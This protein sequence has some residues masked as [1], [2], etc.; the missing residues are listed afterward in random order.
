MKTKKIVR[1]LSALLAAVILCTAFALSASAFSVSEEGNQLYDVTAAD[2]VEYMGGT[3]VLEGENTVKFIE[4]TVIDYDI[5]VADGENIVFDLNGQ[6]VKFSNHYGPAYEGEWLGSICGNGTLTIKDS[7]GTGRF[8]AV[9]FDFPTVIIEGGNF[10][11]P[12]GFNTCTVKNIEIKGGQFFCDDTLNVP[13]YIDDYEYYAGA[14]ILFGSS[15]Y[16]FDEPVNIEKM[17]IA[18][19]VVIDGGT[20]DGISVAGA[21]ES[22]IIEI[23]KA[24]ISG[25]DAIHSTDLYSG[26]DNILRAGEVNIKLDGTV[27]KATGANGRE[28]NVSDNSTVVWVNKPSNVS[29]AI[30]ISKNGVTVTAAENVFPDNTEIVITEIKTDDKIKKAISGLSDNAICFDITALLSG[31][32]VQPNGE[33]AV[34][35][36]VPEKYNIKNIELY[37]VSDSGKAEKINTVKDEKNR[38]LTAKLTHF[39][40]YVLAEQTASGAKTESGN[41]DTSTKKT[42]RSPKTGDDSSVLSMGIIMFAAFGAMA[43]TGK[44]LRKTKC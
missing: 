28:L 37:Y 29:K 8:G 38:T 19:G 14:I 36:S 32:K 10:Y 16:P 22:G 12:I 42:V 3:A 25:F 13:H 7:I 34:T 30:N 26:D 5:F 15:V 21:M 4:E 33:V 35:F 20:T 27:L 2:L 1:L 31:E 44:K 23:G 18:D 11:G 39:S 17:T 6:T 43:V 24:Q 9:E 40:T 41:S